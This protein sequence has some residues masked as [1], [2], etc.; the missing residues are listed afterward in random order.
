MKR[1]MQAR[2]PAPTLSVDEEVNGD[3]A[4]IEAKDIV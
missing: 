1:K 4:A 3:G 2:L